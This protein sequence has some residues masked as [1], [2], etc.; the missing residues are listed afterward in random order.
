MT[1]SP[2]LHARRVRMC[3]EENVHSGATAPSVFWRMAI[4][5]RVTPENKRI[6]QCHPCGRCWWSL[7][8]DKKPRLPQMLLTQLMRPGS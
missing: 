7:S 1:G 8:K 2:A 6:N 3:S 5:D 4:Y